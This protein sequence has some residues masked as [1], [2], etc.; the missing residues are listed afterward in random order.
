MQNC[1]LDLK[2]LGLRA[3]ISERRVTWENIPGRT[4]L[5][6]KQSICNNTHLGAK[7]SFRR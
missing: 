7:A 3:G 5:W 4:L 6:D 1:L 2:S